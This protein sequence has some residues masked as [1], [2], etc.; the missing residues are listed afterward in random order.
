MNFRLNE[1][2]TADPKVLE[3]LGGVGVATT[4]KLLA[5]AKTPDER[6]ALA[7]KAGIDEAKVLAMANRADL[8]RIKGIG[9]V[10]SDLLEHGG[11]DTVLEL[12]RRVPANLHAKLVEASATHHTQRVPRPDEV[13]GWVN[14]AKQLPAALKY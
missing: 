6:K 8:A 10:Y 4:D 2:T 11:V 3:A 7:E 12:S 9:P 1:L 14:Q 5:S 13:E